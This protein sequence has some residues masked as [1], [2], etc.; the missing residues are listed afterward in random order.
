MICSRTMQIDHRCIDFKFNSS[1]ISDEEDQGRCLFVYCTKTQCFSVVSKVRKCFRLWTLSFILEQCP[2]TR[3]TISRRMF[4]E[5]DICSKVSD[6]IA[7]K[8]KF[9]GKA[10]IF[11]DLAFYAPNLL[12]WNLA[13]CTSYA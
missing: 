13:L 5:H 3:M 4:R 1:H 10:E 9:F 6:F 2:H 8:E 11:I 12:T 7:R